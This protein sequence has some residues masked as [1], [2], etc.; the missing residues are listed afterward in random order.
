MDTKSVFLTGASGLLGSHILEHLLTAEYSLKLLIRSPIISA[1]D[2]RTVVGDLLDPTS[3]EDSL[4]GI[5]T[6][7]HCAAMVSYDSK[8][9]KQ[10]YKINVEGTRSL[11]NAA[12]FSGVK[13]F[14]F[15][16]SASTMIRSSDEALVSDQAVG[17]PILKSYYAETKY[18]AELE[19]WRAAAEGLNVCIL[20]PSLVL[21]KGSW[22]HSSM[23][24]FQKVQDGLSFYPPGNLGLIA[25]DDIAKIVL[26]ALNGNWWGKQFLVNAESW[27]YQKFL[28]T[29]A[30][31]LHKEPILHK[32]GILSAKGL[33]LLDGI[34]SAVSHKK[35]II[36][37]ETIRS[38]FS[39][40]YY[41]D[42]LSRQILQYNYQNI[43]SLILLLC[44]NK[45]S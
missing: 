2:S 1:E 16:S 9:R 26:Q 17:Q 21:G 39:Q 42:E 27:T 12:L 20:N 19:V 3:Y 5:D 30:N 44:Q 34:V 10:L 15:I 28:N 24:I 37:T 8:D 45:A 6:I 43:E 7:I 25:A 31:A 35:T 36:N 4:N 29:I 18:L 11:V 33:A 23:Q 40:V 14:I 13:N 22:D 32:A 41:K 38:S